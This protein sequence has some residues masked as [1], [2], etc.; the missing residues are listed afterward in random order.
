[1]SWLLLARK[2]MAESLVGGTFNSGGR[3]WFPGRSSGKSA[4]F[5]PTLKLPAGKQVSGFR[6][7]GSWLVARGSWL[8][9]LRSSLKAGWKR[10]SP[11]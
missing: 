8:L 5:P 3:T 10:C 9:A 1:M 4:R 2:L 7:R 6:V 11:Y